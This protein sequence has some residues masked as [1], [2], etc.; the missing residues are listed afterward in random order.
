MLY[1]FTVYYYIRLRWIFAQYFGNLSMKALFMNILFIDGSSHN[2]EKYFTISL[3]NS[4]N[5][6]YILI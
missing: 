2:Y 6:V 4:Q 1:M 5:I 3:P